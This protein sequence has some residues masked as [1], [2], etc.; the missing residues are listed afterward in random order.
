MPPASSNSLTTVAFILLRLQYQVAFRSPQYRAIW[1]CF[2][3]YL[4]RKGEKLAR[5]QKE[6][7]KIVRAGVRVCV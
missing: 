6:V 5:S 3:Y 7:H 1:D 2:C 4:C